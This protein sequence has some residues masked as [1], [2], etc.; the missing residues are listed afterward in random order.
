MTYREMTYREFT[1]KRPVAVETTPVVWIETLH[2]PLPGT[3]PLKAVMVLLPLTA[4]CLCTIP[5]GAV[6]M[7]SNGALPLLIERFRVMLE[8]RPL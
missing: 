5:F 6:K 2:V 3:R 1:V 7:M 4:R 8:T